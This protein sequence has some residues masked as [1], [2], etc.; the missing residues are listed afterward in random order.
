VALGEYGEVV[1]LDWGLA[2]HARRG[3]GGSKGSTSS[4][5]FG[6]PGY[7][8]PEASRAEAVV[9]ER[10]DVYSL[11]AVLFEIL[12]G[13][14]PAPGAADP[15]AVA[16]EVP[17][18]LAGICARALARE[19]AERTP[20]VAT[21]VRSVREWRDRTAADRE[22]AALVAEAGAL[23]PGAEA[24]PAAE[25]VRVADRALALAAEA[26]RRRQGHEGAEAVLARAGAVR[27]RA[28]RTREAQARRRALRQAGAVALTVAAIAGAGVA[29]SLEERRREAD[30]L[31]MLAQGERRRAEGAMA[32]MLSDL[33]TG[34]EALGRTDLLAQSAEVTR[35]YYETLP[36]SLASRT[37]R[38][39]RVAALST[40]GEVSRA[41]GDLRRALEAYRASAAEAETL[42]AEDPADPQ[43][44][45]MAAR[46]RAR[47][48]RALFERGEREAALVVARRHAEEISRLAA[49]RPDDPDV[50]AEVGPAHTLLGEALLRHGDDEGGLR[51]LREALRAAGT[52]AASRPDDLRAREGAVLARVAVGRWTE[53]PAAALVLLDEALAEARAIVARRPGEVRWRATLADAL[54]RRLHPLAAL[55]RADDARSTYAEALALRTELEA[56]DPSNVLWREGTAR[57]HLRMGDALYASGGKAADVL[58]LFESALAAAEA[59]VAQDAE[60]AGW[61][62][63]VVDASSR[64]QFQR[65]TSGDPSGALRAGRR[66]YDASS[67]LL[68]RDPSNPV[69]RL[70]LAHNACGLGAGL[71]LDTDAAEAA[72]LLERGLD[73]F[74]EQRSTGSDAS[75]E[76]HKR[77]WAARLAALYGALDDGPRRVAALRRSLAYAEVVLS[78][79]KVERRDRVLV[80]LRARE[81]AGTLDAK[82]PAGLAEA[83]ALYARA[84]EVL[85]PAVDEEGPQG[86]LEKELRELE[87]ALAAL[88]EAPGTGSR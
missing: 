41:R 57:L 20:D 6:T 42:L 71:P 38:E 88:P 83:R 14:P 84:I 76:R 55:G 40:L 11:G 68:D 13:R 58:P 2:H 44:I 32:Y 86:T 78:T 48:G 16:P 69:W 19:P 17:A 36:A 18:D 5:P 45:L 49:A 12:T 66:A 72:A 7:M 28:V 3:G 61:L 56:L 62:H 9:D 21:L 30:E 65:R 80:A 4:S 60:N 37:D 70:I 10:G 22:V 75:L 79:P 51:E 50:L 31:R 33:R 47:V 77:E 85:R 23:L 24:L 73:L 39:H 1:V 87:A 43:R 29:W 59:L 8:A 67:R 64:L 25:G 54:E 53:D 46:A 35:R 26:L 81:V 34:L 63:L 52:W 27:E 74:D 82:D 15:R